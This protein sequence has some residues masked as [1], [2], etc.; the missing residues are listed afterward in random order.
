LFGDPAIP[1]NC[2]WGTGQSQDFWT[3]KRG[4][5][6]YFANREG[7]DGGGV[8]VSQHRWNVWDGRHYVATIVLLDTRH[9]DIFVRRAKVGHAVG[10]AP[11]AC[12]VIGLFIVI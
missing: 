5:V 9:A 8:Q 4:K 11:V 6:I 7:F 1:G 12:S 3:E 10:V 2:T